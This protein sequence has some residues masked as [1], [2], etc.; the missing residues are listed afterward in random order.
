M[1]QGAR[2]KM[3]NADV[4]K[5][6]NPQCDRVFKR[7]GEG[8]LFVRAA[9]MSESGATQKTLWLCELCSKQFDLRFDRRQKEF[10]MVRHRRAA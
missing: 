7:L 8:K 1:A 2:I 3:K 9:E 5:C 4:S 6:A 10:R